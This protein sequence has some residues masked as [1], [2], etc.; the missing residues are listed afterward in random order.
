MKYSKIT[1]GNNRKISDR[2]LGTFCYE[3]NRQ[4]D[5]NFPF[6]SDA[7]ARKATIV[8]RAHASDAAAIY[9]LGRRQIIA[10]HQKELSTADMEVYLD[11]SFNKDQIAAELISPNIQYW[12]IQNESEIA[13]MIRISNASS[14]VTGQR[15]RALEISRLYLEPHWIGKSVGFV[16]M[17]HV[18]RLAG[19]Y[20]YDVCWLL[21]WA[22]N[23]QAEKFYARWGFTTAESIQYRIS[24]SNLLAHIMVRN[25]PTIR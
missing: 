12:L 21:V 2:L 11:E 9:D 8:R 25:I 17:R 13:G 14:P 6:M 22:G 7:I 15:R 18:L 16:L 3:N 4:V 19:D 23:I 1:H 20:Q 10:T 24:N 5:L